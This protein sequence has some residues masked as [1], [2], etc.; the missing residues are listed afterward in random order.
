[1]ANQDKTFSFKVKHQAKSIF[2]SDVKRTIVIFYKQI[3]LEVIISCRYVK[4][5]VLVYV[6]QVIEAKEAEQKLLESQ[7]NDTKQEKDKKQEEVLRA[8]EDILSNFA[9]LMETELQCSICNEL[10][11]KVGGWGIGMNFCGLYCSL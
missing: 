6:L 10:F 8:R 4:N 2:L 7:L 5:N 9:E 11:V 3:L 1:M